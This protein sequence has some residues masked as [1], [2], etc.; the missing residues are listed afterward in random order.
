MQKAAVIVGGGMGKRFGASIPKQFLLLKGKPVLMYSLEAFY[1]CDTQTEIV[2][3]LPKDYHNHWKTLCHDHHF[4]LPHKTV[5]GG[6]ERFHSVKNGLQAVETQGVIAIHD[7]VRPL[8]KPAWLSH[9]FLVAEKQGNAVPA[10]RAVESVRLKENQTTRAIN[11]NNVFLIQTPQCFQ[12]QILE[13]AYNQPRSELFTDDASVVEAA[14]YGIHLEEGDPRN[15]KI[16]TPDDIAI[17]ELF[18]TLR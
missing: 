13:K 11:R 3:V 7:A 12:K 2:L 8:I 9:L 1:A 17:A 16:T 14:G 18:M 15:I 5:S 10:C 6:E 4:T